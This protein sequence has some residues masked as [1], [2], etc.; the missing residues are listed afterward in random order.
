MRITCIIKCRQKISLISPRTE[1]DVSHIAPQKIQLAPQK[2]QQKIQQKIFCP[3][4][5]ERQNFE[6]NFI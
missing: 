4:K 5:N 3:V 2:I 6:K 1:N